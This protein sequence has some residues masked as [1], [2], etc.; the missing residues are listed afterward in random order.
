[1][2]KKKNMQS[3]RKNTKREGIKERI[4]LTLGLLILSRLGTFIP[5]P[6]VDHDAF[7]Q[8]ISSNPIVSF[9][10]IFSGGG[11][12][13]IGIFALG[14]VPY[15]NASIIIQL[16]TTSIPSLE[17]LQKEEGEAGRQKISQITRYLAL[18][19]A[20]VQS[21]GVSF[22]VRPYVFNWDTQFVIQ[23]TLAL[24]TGSMLIMWFSEQITEKGIGNGPSLLIFINIIAGLPKLIQQ[25]SSVVNVNTQ[26][27]E[28]F[29]L[30]SIFLIMIVGIIFIQEG[31]RRIPIVSARQL[32]KGQSQSKTS[33]LPLRLNQGGV[34]P[35][36]FASAILVLP[37]YLTQIIKN[38]FLLNFLNLL[39][40][41]SGDKNLYLIFYFSLILFF[42]YFY[43]SLI[44]N[45]NDVSQNLKKM[46][47][48][49]PGVRP[50]KATTDYLQKTLNRLTFLGALFLAFIAV[51]PS[52][53]ENIT[54]ISTFKGLGATSLLILVGVAID[55]SRQIQ[56]YLISR[57]Y[58]N[59]MK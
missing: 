52:V 21:L 54:N 41:N 34:M 5:V 57:N 51:I 12:A 19:W 3:I 58:E 6:G 11:F 56:T 18:G 1:M 38:Q 49:I 13:S 59:I 29:V 23:M 9:L 30:A 2:P 8:S 35:I 22:W 47:S 32:G 42:S 50:G 45:P 43:A 33:Y 44:I 31:T 46:E 10:N 15:I 27:T 40:P 26:L 39:S 7:Y 20:A 24:T 4:F 48:S 36:I 16:A 53:I 28:L 55:T 25:K 37:A 14:I 17:R